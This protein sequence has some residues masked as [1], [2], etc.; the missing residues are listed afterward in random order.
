MVSISGSGVETWRRPSLSSQNRARPAKAASTAAGS[1][2]FARMRRPSSRPPSPSI[3]TSRAFW[4][5]ARVSFFCRT[6]Q[7]LFP[8]ST[9]PEHSPRST[10]AGSD[11]VR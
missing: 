8:F 6:A 1:L 2:Y 3:Q 7:W 11:S 10:A 4:P 5:G 9:E